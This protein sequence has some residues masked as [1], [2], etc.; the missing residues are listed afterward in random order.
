VADLEASVALYSAIA[1][2]INGTDLRE[3]R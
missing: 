2:Q 1:A 3:D